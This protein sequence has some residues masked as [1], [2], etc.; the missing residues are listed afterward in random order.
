MIKYKINIEN[1]NNEMFAWV[2]SN[3]ELINKNIDLEEKINF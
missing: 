2:L 1:L 3:Q